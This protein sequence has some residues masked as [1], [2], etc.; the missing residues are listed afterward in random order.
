[1]RRSKAFV[2]IKRKQISRHCLV[3][4]CFYAEVY[5]FSKSI[6]RLKTTAGNVVARGRA[7]LGFWSHTWTL[8]DGGIIIQSSVGHKGSFESLTDQLLSYS[9]GYKSVYVRPRLSDPD[10]MTDTT[11]EGHRFVKWQKRT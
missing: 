7:G 8:M 11:L 6:R 2:D 1:M 5:S 4:T 9:I 3:I 10:A